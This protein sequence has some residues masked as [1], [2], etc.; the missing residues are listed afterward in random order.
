M[1][2]SAESNLLTWSNLGQLGSSPRK[3]RQQSLMTLLIKYK[4]NCGQP[5]V[6]GTVKT[7]RNPNVFERPPELLPCSPNFT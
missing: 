6:K 5:L 7:L 4:H 3:P 2:E 1:T